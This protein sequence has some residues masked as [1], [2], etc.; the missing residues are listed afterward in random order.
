MKIKE[1][2]EEQELEII[3]DSGAYSAWSLGEVINIEDYIKFI[4]KNE[5]YVDIIINLDVIPG[6]FG[7]VPSEKEVEASAQ[8]GY[9]NLKYLE[10]NNIKAL[11]VF[12]QG[13]K[14]IWLEKL[15]NEGY[16]Y[17]GISPANDRTTEQK[18]V[19]LDTVFAPI[20][21]EDG[22]PKIKTHSFG[23]TSLEILWRYPWW[24]ADSTTWTRAG[25][26]GSVFVPSLIGGIP[27]YSCSP[28]VLCVSD[29]AL[30]S[31]KGNR[32]SRHYSSLS[33]EE[34]AEV[35]GFFS[36]RGFTYESLK[37]S[38]KNR[39]KLNILF[40]LEVEKN[41]PKNRTFNRKKI[42]KSFFSA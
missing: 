40:F 39:D 24:S 2:V 13:E 8:K 33:E 30:K 3:L 1:I 28:N 16:D 25:R 36:V 4:K 17:I 20:C 32:I 26:Y 22:V 15:I 34:R 23:A 27:D 37:N 6:E 14:L 10:K 35:D 31:S 42:I 19:W 5:E 11:P 12:H 41:L 9:E 21:T 29:E 7:R 38:W 18:I